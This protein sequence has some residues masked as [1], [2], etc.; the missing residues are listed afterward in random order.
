MRELVYIYALVVYFEGL[1]LYY[2]PGG[3]IFSGDEAA[4]FL[5][6]ARKFFRDVAFIEPVVGSVDGFLAALSFLQRLLL[7]FHHFLQCFEQVC[8]AEDLSGFG[9][10]ALLA[11]VGQEY[12]FGVRPLLYPFFAAFH[13]VGRLCFYR[14]SIGQLHGRGEYVFK[15]HGAILGKHGAEAAGCAWRYGRRADRIPADS[16]CL[17]L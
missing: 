12:G 17:C 1:F 16:S 11:G 7:G 5:A 4:L 2:F 14:V 9:C 3:Q 8:L 15:A 6:A 10:F 13:G